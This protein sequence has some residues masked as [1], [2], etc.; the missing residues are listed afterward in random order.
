MST[1]TMEIKKAFNAHTVTMK[2]EDGGRTQ[3]YSI[4][5]VEYR[6]SGSLHTPHVIAAIAAQQE[7]SP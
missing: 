7:K 4:D 5:G 3:V 1:G 6:V 2:Y